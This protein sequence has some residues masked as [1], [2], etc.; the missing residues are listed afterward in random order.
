MPEAAIDNRR[1]RDCY[2]TIQNHLI[3]LCPSPGHAEGTAARMVS[4]Y[5]IEYHSQV[6]KASHHFSPP[7]IAAVDPAQTSVSTTQRRPSQTVWMCTLV[8]VGSVAGKEW[9]S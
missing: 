7:L 4:H 1:S 6:S 9:L 3:A 2:H 5:G 8:V